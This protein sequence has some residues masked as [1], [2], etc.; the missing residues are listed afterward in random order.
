MYGVGVFYFM[1]IYYCSCIKLIWRRTCYNCLLYSLIEWYYN[2]EIFSLREFYHTSSTNIYYS[3]NFYISQILFHKQ[4]ALKMFWCICRIAFCYWYEYNIAILIWAIKIVLK[5]NLEFDLVGIN[6][7][8]LKPIS[9]ENVVFFLLTKDEENMCS[10][11]I[12][13]QDCCI[14][15]TWVKCQSKSL[16]MY[17]LPIFVS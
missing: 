10:I 16:D 8:L 5:I 13:K 7:L 6:Y 14:Y 3:Q 9:M 17:W 11:I 4:C 15:S 1:K 12:Q 2:K